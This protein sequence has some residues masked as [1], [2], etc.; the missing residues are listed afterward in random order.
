MRYPFWMGF[1][2]GVGGRGVAAAFL[3]EMNALENAPK[4]NSGGQKLTQ[5][6]FLAFFA[7]K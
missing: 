2:D 6:I 7:L 5:H 4:R 3:K 1:L